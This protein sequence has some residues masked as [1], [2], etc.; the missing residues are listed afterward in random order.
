MAFFCR[1]TGKFLKKE[2]KRSYAWKQSCSFQCSLHWVSPPQTSAESIR[3]H[4]VL[5]S[6]HTSIFCP[7]ANWLNLSSANNF[8]LMRIYFKCLFPQELTF[9]L[10]PA[11]VFLCRLER[12]LEHDE[13][14]YRYWFVLGCCLDNY[15]HWTTTPSRTR[16]CLYLSVA[17]CFPR[18]GM[19]RLTLASSSGPLQPHCPVSCEDTLSK[20]KVEAVMGCHLSQTVQGYF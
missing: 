16:I 19:G 8:H 12:L 1:N 5:F 15:L 13:P 11:W 6:C 17:A 14:Y 18:G 3:K 7:V 9:P 4:Y 10:H 2:L 20:G